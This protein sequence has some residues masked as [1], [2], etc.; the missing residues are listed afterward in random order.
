MHQQRGPACPTRCGLLSSLSN[1]CR[2]G[3]EREGESAVAGVNVSNPGT[4]EGIGERQHSVE[5]GDPEDPRHVPRASRY[6]QAIAVGR[7]APTRIEE[8]AQTGRVD[9][10]QP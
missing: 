7:G 10:R 1:P 6:L 4:Q 9:E 2:L 8:D 5:L 3:W